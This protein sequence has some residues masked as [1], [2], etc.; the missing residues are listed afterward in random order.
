MTTREAQLLQVIRSMAH[1]FSPGIDRGPAFPR[2]CV[3][4][5]EVLETGALTGDAAYELEDLLKLAAAA[6][7]A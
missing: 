1:Y 2:W 4:A 7:E 6:L 3:T 5:R